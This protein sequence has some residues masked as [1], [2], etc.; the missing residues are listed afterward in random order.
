MGAISDANRRSLDSESVPGN[1]RIARPPVV[2]YPI[3]W[4]QCSVPVTRGY[5]SWLLEPREVKAF[6][7]RRRLKH[8][9]LLA[10]LRSA[11]PAPIVRCTDHTLR[12]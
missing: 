9:A 6:R 8:Q 12:I 1:G 10:V 5:M 4:I 3:D 11:P 2:F 7:E